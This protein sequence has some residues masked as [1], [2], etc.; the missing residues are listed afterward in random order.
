VLSGS[1]GFGKDMLLDKIMHLWIGRYQI[2]SLPFYITKTHFLTL[3]S[4]LKLLVVNVEEKDKHP[5]TL[6]SDKLRTK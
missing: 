4:N 1:L 5:N 3:L 2:N 6:S